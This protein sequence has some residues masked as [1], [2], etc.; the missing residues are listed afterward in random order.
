MQLAD[1]DKKFMMQFKAQTLSLFVMAGRRALS[2]PWESC[3]E[4]IW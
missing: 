2:E 4:G 3:H 1:E